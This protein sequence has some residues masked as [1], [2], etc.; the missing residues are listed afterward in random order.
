MQW[1]TRATTCGTRRACSACRFSSAAMRVPPNCSGAEHGR[2]RDHAAPRGTREDAARVFASADALRREVCGERGHVCRDPEHPVHDVCYFGCGSACSRRESSR[3]TS[4]VRRISS[5]VRRSCDA[6]RRRGSAARPRSASRRDPPAFTGDYYADVVRPS[7][8]WSRRFMSTRSRR[9]RLAGAY[10]RPVA[11]AVPRDLRDLGLGSLP[12][13]AAEVL[14]DEVRRV[15][16]PDKAT[17]AQWLAVHDAAHRVGLRSTSR[18]CSACRYAVFVGVSFL[19]AA[20]SSV[21]RG[22]SPS[23]SRCRSCRWKRRST[24]RGARGEGRHSARRCSSTRSRGSRCIRT[25][26][27]VEASG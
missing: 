5:R 12:G 25:M 17:T 21:A 8:R 1:A 20:S 10:A 16:C 6:R 19:R 24:S 18:S 13:T 4:A 23:S 26:S 2:G 27:D 9:S 15:I 3:R 14:D 22:D 11:R 7:S